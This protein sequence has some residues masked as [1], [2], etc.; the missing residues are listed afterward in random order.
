MLED[1]VTETSAY[2]RDDLFA[3]FS[4]R[5]LLDYVSSISVYHVDEE[6][7]LWQSPRAGWV[8]SVSVEEVRK[9]VEKKDQ[10]LVGYR[11]NCKSV[12]LA[13]DNRLEAGLYAISDKARQFRY[14]HGFDRIFWI[15]MRN[16]NPIPPN[17]PIL[18]AIRE[19]MPKS[20]TDVF[21]VY[22]LRSKQ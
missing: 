22:E 3:L 14:R 11:K 4:E 17:K 18:T 13:I 10:K 12:W 2:S 19:N 20:R 16:G 8:A 1:N 6:G 7:E 9:V 15:E 21:K 5:G